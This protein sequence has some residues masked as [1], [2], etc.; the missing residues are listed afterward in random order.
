[1]S[2]KHNAS[3]FITWSSNS[4]IGILD[5]E[6]PRVFN[7]WENTAKGTLE[8]LDKWNYTDKKITCT[9]YSCT[10][11]TDINEVYF[12]RI[13]INAL[14]ELAKAELEIEA[15]ALIEKIAK[16]E[17]QLNAKTNQTT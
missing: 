7:T 2:L 16:I 3:F 12:Q 11:C 8:Q 5:G 13:E 1:M 15:K 9:V 14:R 4:H 6:A 17:S 10:I